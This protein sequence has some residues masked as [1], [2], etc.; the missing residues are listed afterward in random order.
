M[1]RMS[2]GCKYHVFTSSGS[3]VVA[4]GGDVEFLVIGGGGGAGAGVQIME[5]WR[6]WR[7]RRTKMLL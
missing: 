2:G 1:Q 3:L 4:A 5:D 7:S 6:R